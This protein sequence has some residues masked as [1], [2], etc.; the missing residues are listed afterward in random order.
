MKLYE[1]RKMKCLGDIDKEGYFLPEDLVKV[2]GSSD[3][4]FGSLSDKI[5]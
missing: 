4:S 1:F 2:H 3:S 5:K